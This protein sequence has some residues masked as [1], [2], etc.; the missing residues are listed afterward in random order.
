MLLTLMKSKIHRATVTQADLNYVGSL[1]LDPDLMDAADI[2][3]HEKV[4][5]LNVN[6]GARFETYAIE[7]AR[8]SGVCCLNGPAARQG[9]PG[10]IVIVVTYAQ[11]DPAEARAHRPKNVHVDAHN[12]ITEIVTTPET[13]GV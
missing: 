10:D 4:Q 3:L 5:V 1:T 11:M 12:R 13:N 9:Q 8:G 6:N 7:G 2:F